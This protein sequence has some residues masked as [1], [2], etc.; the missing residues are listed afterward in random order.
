MIHRDLKPPNILVD[1]EGEPHILD[2]GLAKAVHRNASS[3]STI[4]VL[5]TSGQLLGTVAYMSPE[6]AAGSQDVDVRSDVYSLGVVFYDALVGH[7]PYAVDGPLG[8]VL[9]RIAHD[10]PQNPRSLAAPQSAFRID[11]ELATILLKSLE[12]EPQRRYQTAGDLARDLR[13]RLLGE[14]IEAKRA[15]GLYMFKKT[16]RRY[17]LQAAMAGL[18]LLMLIGFLITFA[19]LFTSERDARRR[20]DEKSELA[21]RAVDRQDAALAAAHDSTARAVQAKQKLLRALGR[22]RIQRGDLALERADLIAARDSY[23]EAL[24][25]APGPAAVWALRRFHTLT[26]SSG[27]EL[28]A[29]E[30]HGPSRLSPNGKLTAVCP[31]PESLWVRRTDTGEIVTW[32]HMPSPATHIALTND[33]ALAAAGPTW[34]CV[35]QPGTERPHVAVQLLDGA[36][37]HALVPV[38]GGTGLLLLGQRGGRLL[39]GVAGEVGAVVRF[40]GKPTGPVDY[41]R[42]ARQIAIPTTAGVELVTVGTDELSH[43]IIWS[44]PGKTARAGRVDG[45]AGRAGLADDAIYVSTTPAR[46]QWTRMFDVPDAATVSAQTGGALPRALPRIPSDDTG[47]APT[48]NPASSAEPDQAPPLGVTA[49]T[50]GT[51]PFWDMFDLRYVPGAAVLGTHDGHLAILRQDEPSATWRFNVDRLAE[52]RLSL[53]EQAVVTLDERGTVSRWIDPSRIEQRREILDAPPLTWAT[54]GDGSTI[55]MGLPR[56][57]VVAYAP[58]TDSVPRTL[59]RPRLIAVPRASDEPA[60]SVA[61]SADGSRGLIRDGTSLRFVT[62]GGRNV[63]L[64]SWTHPELSVPDRV[65]LSGDGEIA[66]LVARSPLGDEQRVAFFRWPGGD[67]T[68]KPHPGPIDFVGALIRDIAFI[69]GTHTLLVARSNGR[70]LLIDADAERGGTTATTGPA[71]RAPQNLPWSPTPVESWLTLDAPPTLLACSRT[72]EYLAVAC[73][74][75]AVRLIAMR[76]ETETPAPR[77][78]GAA[79]NTDDVPVSTADDPNARGLG[80]IGELSGIQAG[81]RGELRFR[82]G[83]AP[84]VTSL[85]F[86]PRDDV[87]LLRTADGNIRLCDPTT[88][89]DIA[90]WRQPA[91]TDHP[92]AAW[93]GEADAMLLGYGGG[94]FEHRYEY[95]DNLI[96]RNRPY[97]RERQIARLLDNG[98]VTG[99]WAATADLAARD[100]RRG[101]CA[102]I[103]LLEVALRRLKYPVPAEWGDAVLLPETGEAALDDTRRGATYLQLG[104][105]AYDGEQFDLAHAWLARGRELLAGDAD[106]PADADPNAPSR[107]LDSDLDAVTLRRIAETDYLAENYDAAAAGFAEVLR[108]RDLDPATVPTL[109]LERTAALVLAGRTDE[110]RQVALR[111]GEP[112]RRGYGDLVALASARIISRVLA[113]LEDETFASAAIDDL[114]T[115]FDKR[116]LYWDDVPFFVGE[117]ARARGDRTQA[118]VQYQRC[119]DLARDVWPSNWARY[120]LKHLAPASPTQ[121]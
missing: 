43:A 106:E 90:T 34:A 112:V 120:R 74:D 3:D 89:D 116:L 52:V 69:P 102:R 16:L 62:L 4:Q 9:Q 110:A 115:R 98:D 39:R 18:I 95:A 84:S 65:A 7:P 14:P 55:L 40:A 88:G 2:F 60:V 72:G 81:W 31:G 76:R 118:A 45:A 97:V 26:A 86:N 8:E 87:L 33:G 68:A 48:T 59:L 101:R 1:R 25:V 111:L 22:E 105:A 71:T 51:T 12:K 41:A 53:A 73:E 61:I 37:L 49:P 38:D 21:R 30:S 46:D 83:S 121:P 36:H 70:L 96:E 113:G 13:H 54:A 119:V 78:A 35:W 103:N 47:S 91:G 77:P 23:W 20:A 27:A 64:L 63:A 75:E 29:L 94:V 82:I 108:R 117:L 28:L 109:M 32:V 24:D 11:D 5:S 19:V 104:H 67:R 79:P 42:N 80:A 44:A 10:D 17:R 57:R 56:G 114:V 58:E 15:S 85:A 6:Q 107:P 50:A 66:A 99:A 93:I 100:P 92:M